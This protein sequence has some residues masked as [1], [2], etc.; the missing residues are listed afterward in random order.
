MF[1]HI[2][3]MIKD[4]QFHPNAIYLD[5]LEKLFYDL[6]ILLLAKY[7]E[8]DQFYLNTNSRN[9]VNKISKKH[10]CHMYVSNIYLNTTVFL[11]MTYL[12]LSLLEH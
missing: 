2:L 11:L 6:T 12:P 10:H 5:F 7:Q 1:Y 4:H 8:M 3:C 9:N